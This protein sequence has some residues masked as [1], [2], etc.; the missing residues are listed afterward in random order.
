MKPEN[1]RLINAFLGDFQSDMIDEKWVEFPYG[2][3]SRKMI[4]NYGRVAKFYLYEY[5]C[6]KYYMPKISLGYYRFSGLNN[7][8]HILLHRIVAE[9]FLPKIEGKDFINHKNG[10]KLDNRVDNLEWC[11]LNENNQHAIK[12]GL[13]D[14][15]GMAHRMSKITDEIARNI[16]LELKSGN[17]SLRKIA[18]KF[19]VS[20]GIVFNIKFKDGWK[21]IEI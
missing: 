12:Y 10:N 5:N 19:G 9:L 11:T 20:N 21:H 17:L 4:S 15:R 6:W 14:N 1:L 13:M 8:K 7:G 18:K 2:K 16:K 3:K